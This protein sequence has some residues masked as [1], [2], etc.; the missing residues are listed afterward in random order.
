MPTCN[1]LS[2]ICRIPD[3]S[4]L[5]EIYLKLNGKK[6]W[7]ESKKYKSIKMGKTDLNF[8]LKDVNHSD[9]IEIELWDY[10]FISVNDFL[11]TFTF[12]LDESG[13]PFTTDLSKKSSQVASYSLE[14][15]YD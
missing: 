14:W 13:G 2:L 1:I 10:D 5:D 9:K 4:D 7:P 6:I 15:K 8:I 11:G 12:Y 3:E